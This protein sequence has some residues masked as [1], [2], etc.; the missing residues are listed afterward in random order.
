MQR[1][2][3]MDGQQRFK[4]RQRDLFKQAERSRQWHDGPN[5]RLECPSF[6]LLIVG[7]LGL[8]RGS[9]F[10]GNGLMKTGRRLDG[11]RMFA[12]SSTSH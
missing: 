9:A 10:V 7:S 8:L 12:D 5:E 3:C 2:N 4:D 11:G 1:G 6:P